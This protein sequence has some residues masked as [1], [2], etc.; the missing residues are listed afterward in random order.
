MQPRASAVMNR[1]SLEDELAR[2]REVTISTCLRQPNAQQ[3]IPQTP[4]AYQHSREP[5][6]PPNSQNSDIAN[7]TS[8][9]VVDEENW[10]GH[11]SALLGTQNHVLKTLSA[12]NSPNDE[13]D[14][15]NVESSVLMQGRDS[16][17]DNVALPIPCAL[18]NNPRLAPLMRLFFTGH[19]NCFYC[20][21]PDPFV[22]R[23]SHL[24]ENHSLENG[25][26]HIP[27]DKPE[28]ISLAALACI[29]LALAEFLSIDLPI[30]TQDTS[31]NTFTH[32]MWNVEARRLLKL[33]AKQ[34]PMN[35]DIVRF[36]LVATY[37]ATGLDCISQEPINGAYQAI[38]MTVTSAY[39][40]G[41]NNETRWAHLSK[42]EKTSRR[43][44]W[45]SIDLMDKQV[46]Y[47]CGRPYL[48]QESEV[49]VSDLTNDIKS[50]DDLSKGGATENGRESREAAKGGHNDTIS[51]ATAP[52]PTPLS[53][54]THLKLQYIQ[55]LIEITHIFTRAWRSFFSVRGPSSCEK[56]EVQSIDALFQR[57]QRNFPADLSWNTAQFTSSPKTIETKSVFRVRLLLFTRIN[58]LRLA[59]HHAA[60]RGRRG[61]LPLAERYSVA[62]SQY[63]LALCDD[64][65]CMTLAAL[66]AY[67]DCC[68]PGSCLTTY[69]TSAALECIYHPIAIVQLAV[70]NSMLSSC[71]LSDRMIATLTEATQI[72]RKATCGSSNPKM[73]LPR[74]TLA[75]IEGI[76]N[77]QKQQNHPLAPTSQARSP[78]AAPAAL[79]S[80]KDQ[81][82]SRQ[83]DYALGV[84]N[85]V[86]LHD[87]PSARDPVA[88]FNA[89][90][91]F[92]SSLLPTLFLDNGRAFD[93]IGNDFFPSGYDMDLEP[94][95]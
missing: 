93:F 82:S 38:A 14:L 52:T 21:D 58:V 8:R 9:M 62:E 49:A 17:G 91:I 81:L 33:Y 50:F 61:G 35:I 34:S 57:I 76:L 10:F 25:Q 11:G 53:L 43:C 45:A 94:S 74:S 67:L 56:D 48:I 63:T 5:P 70:A 89:P 87:Q 12:E 86:A 95:L 47:K 3:Q 13:M 65:A 83:S 55:G 79:P 6:N 24:L 30:T 15:S 19:N 1:T 27:S 2:M 46:A 29:V 90:Y 22:A 16:N 78:S 72:F 75:L 51:S 80:L 28:L 23:L 92:D 32:Q 66:F 20:L 77:H 40:I 68:A 69:A 59:I 64:I 41:L 31:I 7:P 26:L 73:Q 18:S 88:D 84:P 71:R 39:S 60:I 42:E 37:Y 36:H 44:L 85:D 54:S 4:P